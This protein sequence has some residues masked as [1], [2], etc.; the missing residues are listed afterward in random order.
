MR[1]A[2]AIVVLLA[3]QSA[4]T[5]DDDPP[6][7]EKRSDDDD[8]GGLVK[9]GTPKARVTLPGGKFML[10]AVVEANMAKGTA[11]KPL[12][13]APDLWIGVADRLSFGIVHSG[14]GATGFLTSFGT[15]LCFRGGGFCDSGLGK[16]YTFSEAD[17]RI[18]L[19]QGGFAVALVL[20]AQARAFDPDLVLSG[21]AGFLARMGSSR[22][23]LELAPTAFIGITQRKIAGMDFNTDEFGAPVTI[24]LRIAGGFSLALQSGVTF[25]FK[26]IGNTWQIPAAAGFQWW[27]TP[28]ISF[29][30]AFGLAAVADSNDA[31]KAF[32]QRSASVGLGYAL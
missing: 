12:S 27:L 21:K 16:V 31:T 4:A 1:F 15:G 5:A 25:T 13:V 26:D 8:G 10:T 7:A 22:I 9:V 20:G 17:A 29:D 28:H 32:D 19:T 2:T 18:G 24:Y 14:R 30:A 3:I 23:A 6:T 11:G